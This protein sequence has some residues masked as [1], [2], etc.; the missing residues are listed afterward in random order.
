MKYLKITITKRYK[1]WL[2]LYKLLT[3]LIIILGRLRERIE[4][5]LTLVVR[6]DRTFEEETFPFTL[7]CCDC[8]LSHILWVEDKY[9]PK[10]KKGF[11]LKIQPERPYGYDYSFRKFARRCG[12]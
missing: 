5:K 8:G 11:I 3:Q 7:V 10:R 6:K 1:F 2:L 12:R 4:K 9:N